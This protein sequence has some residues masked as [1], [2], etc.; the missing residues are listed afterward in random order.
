MNLSLCPEHHCGDWEGFKLSTLN[1]DR[2]HFYNFPHQINSHLLLT[3]LCRTYNGGH[4]DYVQ[5]LCTC[6][7]IFPADFSP[8]GLLIS[9]PHPPLLL[10]CLP[11]GN[12]RVGISPGFLG[13]PWQELQ[14]PEPSQRQLCSIWSTPWLEL[15]KKWWQG[16]SWIGPVGI[17]KTESLNATETTQ[18]PVRGT[19][20]GPVGVVLMDGKTWACLPP[21]VG[22]WGSLGLG[23]VAQGR[24]GFHV[25]GRVVNLSAFSG[26]GILKVRFRLQPW[27]NMQ[28][29]SECLCQDLRKN[30]GLG[31]PRMWL[32]PSALN[33]DHPQVHDCPGHRGRRR[34]PSSPCPRGQATTL[35]SSERQK[36]MTWG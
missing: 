33:A 24:A 5:C 2:I 29:A 7:I 18:S 32:H 17:P 14:Q 9:S 20:H 19:Y 1:T 22:V 27:E 26:L 8:L 15:L 28:L 25:C 30:R 16:S 21:G 34:V 10:P 31:G 35:V 6:I 4:T 3:L 12:L 11:D 23:N 13:Y 36:K